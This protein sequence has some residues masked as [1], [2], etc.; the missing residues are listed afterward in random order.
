MVSWNL[1]KGRPVPRFV[2]DDITMEIVP[3]FRQSLNDS[4][5]LESAME[6]RQLLQ[7][8]ISNNSF[9]CALTDAGIW[10]DKLHRDDFIVNRRRSRLSVLKQ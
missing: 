1:D 8:S 3:V 9:D 5:P 6:S 10:S 7:S 2:L 4:E